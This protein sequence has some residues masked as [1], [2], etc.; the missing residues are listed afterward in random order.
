MAYLRYSRDSDWYVFHQSSDTQNRN[1]EVLAVW[2]VDHRIE[3]PQFTYA[4][5]KQ[6]LRRNDFSEIPGYSAKYED[7]IKTAL[8]EF[9]RDIDTDYNQSG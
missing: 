5:V 9:V 6:M 2:H 1:E 8:E 7:Q 4:Q 3:S